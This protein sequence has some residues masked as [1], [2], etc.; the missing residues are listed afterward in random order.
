MLP[1]LK[2][3]RHH[4]ARGG[5]TAAGAGSSP[6]EVDHPTALLLPFSHGSEM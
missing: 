2:Q 6:G 3:V 4:S 1:N 5:L